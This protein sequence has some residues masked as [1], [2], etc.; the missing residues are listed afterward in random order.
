MT[1]APPSPLPH[2]L[3]YRIEWPDIQ[4]L[5]CSFA[6]QRLLIR[7]DCLVTLMLS[8]SRLQY[9]MEM[10][11]PLKLMLGT[12]CCRR[13]SGRASSP[14]QRSRRLSWRRVTR[15]MTPRSQRRSWSSQLQRE[16]ASAKSR[17][18]AHWSWSPNSPTAASIAQRASKSPVILLG[19]HTHT[20]TD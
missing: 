4:H 3:Y 13:E 14:F 15:V 2:T 7:P 17:T 9:W 10:K 5:L 1:D 12:P 18:R 19:T 11:Q 16:T 20:H 8:R 6:D